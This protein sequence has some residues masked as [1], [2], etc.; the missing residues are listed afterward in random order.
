MQTLGQI[1]SEQA[2]IGPASGWILVINA[3]REDSQ[4]VTTSIVILGDPCAAGLRSGAALAFPFNTSTNAQYRQHPG[5]HCPCSCPSQG[6]QG[7]GSLPAS[8]QEPSA[9]KAREVKHWPEVLFPAARRSVVRLP[10]A[11]SLRPSIVP[12][13]RNP[14]NC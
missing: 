4:Y 12:C 3:L 14:V 10:P 7:C 1:E 8:S 6:Q 5:G 13:I 11:M 2:A 9:L